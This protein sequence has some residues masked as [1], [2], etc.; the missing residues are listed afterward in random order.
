MCSML[1]QQKFLTALLERLDTEPTAVVND[2]TKLRSLVIQSDSMSL[3]VA[4]DWNKMNA[5]NI[6]LTL[7]F[8]G[9]C[10]EPATTKDRYINV[11]S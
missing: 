2:L 9:L 8:Q 3:H 1:Y 5:M 11:L 10:K 6:E 4:A 7:P